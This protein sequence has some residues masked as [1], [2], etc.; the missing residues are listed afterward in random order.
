MMISLDYDEV[1]LEDP[2]LALLVEACAVSRVPH[3]EHRVG[4]VVVESPVLGPEEHVTLV[5]KT[6]SH[7]DE[8]GVQSHLAVG[9]TRLD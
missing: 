2:Q 6:R 9:G 5:S 7:L 8:A 3:H 1:S 4:A